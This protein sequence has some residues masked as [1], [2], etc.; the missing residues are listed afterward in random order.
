MRTCARSY[1]MAHHLPALFLNQASLVEATGMAPKRCAAAAGAS[2]KKAKTNEQNK[3]YSYNT[4]QALGAV[5][6][7]RIRG[8]RASDGEDMASADSLA[9][10]ADTEFEVV[11]GCI[12]PNRE[13][14]A[15]IVDAL[16]EVPKPFAGAL[17]DEASRVATYAK[18]AANRPAHISPK[19]VITLMNFVRVILRPDEGTSDHA[20][21]RAEAFER[22]C[23]PEFNSDG[24]MYVYASTVST[25]PS[26]WTP[27]LDAGAEIRL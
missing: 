7:Q 23:L 3:R 10:V 26:A 13:A 12:W 9:I 2:S 14:R 4:V 19:D 1:A 8:V 20:T 16:K 18:P 21:D 17:F 24:F 22:V 5:V 6:G 15:A 11:S 27:A 25:T